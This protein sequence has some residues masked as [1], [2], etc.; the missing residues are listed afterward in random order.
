M[1]DWNAWIREIAYERI[2]QIERQLNTCP[3]A[4]PEFADAAGKTTLRFRS[5][6]QLLLPGH[7]FRKIRRVAQGGGENLVQHHIHHG[8]ALDAHGL[9][10]GLQVDLM[11]GTELVFSKY[12]VAGNQGNVLFADIS[13]QRLGRTPQI[14]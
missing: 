4:F 6:V 13:G 3:E 11:P 2:D 14:A 7:R 10:V 8:A 9:L 1:D 12:T 5:Q